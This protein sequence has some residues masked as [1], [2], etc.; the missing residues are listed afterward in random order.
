MSNSSEVYDTG[1]DITDYHMLDF[2]ESLTTL[3]HLV[4]IT[5]LEIRKFATE[6]AIGHCLVK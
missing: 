4:N 2:Q 5:K 1:F 3:P 6:A